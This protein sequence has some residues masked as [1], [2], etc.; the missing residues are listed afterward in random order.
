M[1]GTDRVIGFY[2]RLPGF[3]NSSCGRQVLFFNGGAEV[4]PFPSPSGRYLL[5]VTAPGSGAALLERTNASDPASPFNTT[6]AL[7]LSSGG[8]ALTY[9]GPHEFFGCEDDA[10]LAWPLNK[11]AVGWWHKNSTGDGTWK[12]TATLSIPTAGLPQGE[13]DCLTLTTVGVSWAGAVDDDALVMAGVTANEMCPG[14]TYDGLA[15]WSS[16]T[17]GVDEGG[18]NDWSRWN[19]TIIREPHSEYALLRSSAQAGQ[20]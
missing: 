20:V 11:T 13:A 7:A 12:Q 4:A 9:T 6:P 14:N 2:P 3:Q 16:G 5:V 19:A 15:L 18:K 8:F 1:D 17:P 10:C